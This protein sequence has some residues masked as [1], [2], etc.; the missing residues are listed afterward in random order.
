MYRLMVKRR[1]NTK[2]AKEDQRF[3]ISDEE[4]KR[5]EDRRRWL[6]ATSYQVRTEAQS[7]TGDWYE[8]RTDTNTER[9]HV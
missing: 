3:G 8:L 5:L 1:I 4:Y 6:I 9:A 7:F 2:R